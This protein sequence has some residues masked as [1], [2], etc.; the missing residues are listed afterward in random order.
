[1]DTNSLLE[2]HSFVFLWALVVF[3][4]ALAGVITSSEQEFCCFASEDKSTKIEYEIMSG[5]VKHV[6]MCSKTTEQ[7]AE[8][9]R[10]QSNYLI[11]NEPPAAVIPHV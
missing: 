9:S 5:A 4:S 11:L 3:F 2:T 7:R 1:M 6:I 10:A 8:Q